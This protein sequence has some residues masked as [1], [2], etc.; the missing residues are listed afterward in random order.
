MYLMFKSIKSTLHT[1]NLKES[2]F[3]QNSKLQTMKSK[4]TCQADEHKIH[5]QDISKS[6]FD[7]DLITVQNNRK[8]PENDS[9]EISNL[10]N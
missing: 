2:H 4:H 3:A 10:S 7:E 9:H 8:E 1:Q 6:L 5:L